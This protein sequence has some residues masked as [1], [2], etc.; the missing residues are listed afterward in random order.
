M[1]GEK[2]EKAERIKASKREYARKVREKAKLEGKMTKSDEK[3]ERLRV[4]K[5]TLDGGCTHLDKLVSL[6][7][8]L[9][10]LTE[11]CDKNN[12]N[13]NKIKPHILEF[14]Q[15]GQPSSIQ[16][17]P[18]SDK[19]DH[20]FTLETFLLHTKSPY[21]A[22]NYLSHLNSIKQLLGSQSNQQFIDTLKNN[23][24]DVCT[25]LNQQYHENVLSYIAPIIFLI[26]NFDDIK[27][28]IGDEVL[29]I[30]VDKL[31]EYKQ[32]FLYLK[33]I[34]TDGIMSW[35]QIV[36]LRTKIVP[37]Y[38]YGFYHLLISLYT[39]I[40]PMRDDF[41]LVKIIAN[42]TQLNN[43][44]NFYVID[45][46]TFHF[47]H[48]KTHEKYKSFQFKAPHLLQDV[49]LGSLK[50]NPRP[51]LITQ[52]LNQSDQPYKDGKLATLF[53]KTF[54]IDHNTHL[55]INDFRHAFETYMGQFGIDFEL[56]EKR[57]I[58][59]IIGHDSDQR[60]FYIRDQIRSK[61]LFKEKYDKSADITQ[62]ISDKIGGFYDIGDQITPYQ[63][64]PPI[65][66]IKITIK[67][68]L[69]TQ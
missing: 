60:D 5:Q 40:P 11:Y 39:C 16:P 19:Y 41:G 69:L 45:T 20:I 38:K 54:K 37:Q 48:Y 28:F 18:Q 55:T 24:I 63:P 30:Y 31:S 68:K 29:K 42:D 17:E 34:Q 46:N 21:T 47:N 59:Q 22:R 62:R 44:D 58:N 65:K 51:Y 53:P 25:Q 32:Q 43:T 7:I 9:S 10:V 61:P 49:I 52:N 2:L 13:L 57:W 8:N 3:K 23:P 1:D 27:L 50:Q 12:C 6:N 66:K 56:E 4:I 15:K 67:R 26:R 35:D 64:P 14:L 33:L 36:N